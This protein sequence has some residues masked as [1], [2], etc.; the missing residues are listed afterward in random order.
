[1]PSLPSLPPSF[2]PPSWVSRPV[3]APHQQDPKPDV[4]DAFVP[5]GP[6][7]W[8]PGHVCLCTPL[9]PN[10]RSKLHVASCGKQPLLGL[11]DHSCPHFHLHLC[12]KE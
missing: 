3:M 9:H 8:S 1:M 11:L 4:W 10:T 5:W 6:I 2:L 12:K 7:L